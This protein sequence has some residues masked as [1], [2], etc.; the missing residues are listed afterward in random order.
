MGGLT[1]RGF[2]L[3]LA[4]SLAAAPALAQTQ[5]DNGLTRHPFLL[6][7]EWDHRKSEQTL[8][9]VRDG[10][11]SWSYA[12]GGEGVELGDASLLPGGNIL[13]AHKTGASEVTPDKRIVWTID[14]RANAE[15]HT[16]QP[17]PHGRV[18]VVENGNPARLMVIHLKSGKLEKQLILPV[19]NPDKPHIQFRRVRRTPSG[20]WLAGHLDDQ[21]VVEYDEDGKA[22]WTYA[23][24]R[25]WGVDRLKNGNTLISCYEGKASQ[26]IEVTPAGKMVWRFSQDDVADDRCFQ[27]QGVKR[28]RNGN[29]V[30]C[31]W[32]A[33][34]L[35]DVAQWN[36]TVQVF[37]VAPDKRIVWTLRAWDQPDLGTGSSIQ[38]LD[39]PG[40]PGVSA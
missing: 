11:L 1:R 34:D 40:G 31:N 8:Y 33:G 23:I 15:I 5:A 2:Q 30:V 20:T 24:D 13:F 26:V 10:R 4:A 29:T 18:M 16:L 32:C 19:P 28:L 14:A 37:E 36:G 27:F 9:L 17:L 22:I 3:G 35:R 6:S 7:G 25:P 21:K 12:M 38:L 39:Q